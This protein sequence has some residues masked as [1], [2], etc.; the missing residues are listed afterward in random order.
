MIASVDELRTTALDFAF[1]LMHQC[2]GFPGKCEQKA[3][4]Y[5]NTRKTPL[6]NMF[7]S[8]IIFDVDG[9]GYSDRSLVLVTSRS[10]VFK[11]TIYREFFDDWLQPWVQFV[12]ISMHFGEIL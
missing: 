4:D 8:K 11:F 10:A 9:M 12:P 2:G 6:N 7:A 3:K 5:L 1:I